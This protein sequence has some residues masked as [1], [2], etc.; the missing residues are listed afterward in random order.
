MGIKLNQKAILRIIGLAG[1]IVFATFFVFTYAVPDWVEAYAAGFIEQKASKK[2]DQAI[3]GFQPPAAEGALSRFANTLYAKNEEKIIE[4]KGALKAKVHERMADV[5]AAIKDPDCE[6]REKYAQVIKQGFKFDMALLQSANDRIVDLIQSKYM[7]VSS[8]LKHDIRI[9]TGANALVFLFLLLV[10][11]V[12]PQAVRHLF[13]PGSLLALSTLS[14]S[15]FYVFEQNWLLTII[16]GDYLGVVYL[17]YL[18]GV[19][20]FLCDI[21]LNKARVTTELINGLFSAVGAVA[22]LE[23]C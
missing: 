2:I 8:E 21:V 19:F 17:V 15:Y 23:P 20:L 13:L 10:S 7:Q 12:K 3:D 18:A 4:L 1:T 11:F 6:C 9:F 5:L 22:E 14:C 16:Y